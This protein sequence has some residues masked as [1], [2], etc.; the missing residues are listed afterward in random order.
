MGSN[1]GLP[2]E[3]PP[4]TVELDG[5]WIDEHEVTNQQFQEFVEAT[6]YIT[7]A[8]QTPQPQD[9][10]GVPEEKLVPGSLVFIKP[11]GE[12][13]R[14]EY[15]PGASWRNVHGQIP[16]PNLIPNHPVVHVA[17]E[18]AVAYAKWAGK[19]LPTE[20][21]FEYAFAWVKE[22]G[23]PT[24][25]QT[26]P[27]ANVW[28]GVFPDENRVEDGFQSLAP[29]KSFPPNKNGLYDMAGNVWE[30]CHDW[31]HPNAYESATTKNPTGPTNSFDPQ[32]PNRPKRVMRGGS[33]LCSENYCRGWRPTA[34][35]KSTPD[36]GLSHTGFRCVV[37]QIDPAADPNFKPNPSAAV[38]TTKQK[39]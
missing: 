24:T 10:P 17:W 32:E 28:Q 12:P 21:Q 3:S 27:N 4:H 25:P 31:Y 26:P 35:M 23:S 39:E 34:R 18:D 38:P 7:V 11:K 20:A 29:V 15:V 13:G 19:S 9:F 36:T 2:D 22:S 30:W 33:Y 5:F 37:N 6:G 8:E 14:W 1:D 16:P